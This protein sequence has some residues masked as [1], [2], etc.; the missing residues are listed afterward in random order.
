[1]NSPNEIT[2]SVL[3][4]TER[5]LGS[6]TFTAVDPATG[7]HLS[8]AFQEAGA[9]DV[10]A[11]CELAAEACGVFSELE[12]AARARFLRCAG[13]QIMALGDAL[14]ERAMSETGLPRVRLQGERLRTVGQLEFF[15][16]IVQE[17]AWIDA[18]IDPAKPDRTPLPRPDLRRRHVALGPVAVFGAS[19]FP[20][21]FSVAGGDS[22]AALAAGCPV[23]V[24][25]HPAHPGTGELVAR[26]M[27]AA[28]QECLLPAGTFSYLPG[29]TQSLGA[30]LVA[31]PRIRAVGFTGSRA[32]G[33]A[34]AKIAAARPDPIPVFAEMS[35]INP[36]ILFP[37]AA[38]SRGEQLGRAYVASV[39]LGAGQFCTNPGV[40]LYLEGTD[41]RPFL[42]AATAALQ[43]CPAQPMLGSG[44]YNHYSQAVEQLSR[45]KSVQSLGQG[46]TEEGI[47]RARGALFAVDAEHFIADETLRQ[48]VFGPASLV[49]RAQDVAQLG[50]VVDALEGQLTAT[51]LFDDDDVELV[52][53]L[54]PRLQRK[55]G[56]ILG[57]GWPT[58]VEVCHAMVHGGPYP[59]TTDGR[60]TSVGALAIQRFLRPIC[61]QNLPDTLLPPALRTANPFRLTR[62]V[63]GT[64]VRPD[65]S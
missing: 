37:A 63:D 8:P 58:G 42:Q 41:V 22:A 4:G 33:L 6:H 40:L 3:V 15:A 48:E 23:V 10:A 1:M 20:L 9:Q 46:R 2:G 36:V 50:R 21:A 16:D 45:H 43:E 64:V 32:G 53:P 38:R 34:L 29:T 25:G 11:A 49:V 51:L 31:D 44:I 24:K 59:A 26:A 60:S 5:N 61:Y 35:S 30:T 28:V 52:G 57:N 18:T 65:A 55:V 54:L 27:R 19:N 14:I 39:T 47:N 12:P 62:R 17:G 13:R 56:R 7:A